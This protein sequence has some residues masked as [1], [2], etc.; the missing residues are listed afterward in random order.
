ML[1]DTQKAPGRLPPGRRVYAIGD[2]HGCGEQL[3]HLHAAIVADLHRR[4]AADP[5]L[6]HLGDYVDR[7]PDIAG[8][9]EKLAVGDPIA[10]L[11]T[12][13]LLGN[14]ERTMLDALMGDRAAATDWLY[15]GGRESLASYGIHPDDDPRDVWTQRVP[16]S[17]V[18]FLKGLTLMHREGS[19][20]FAHA[21]IRPGV[22]LHAQEKHDLI[23]IRTTFLFSEAD[24]GAVVVHGHTPTPTRLP[25]IKANRIA[26]DTGAVYGG[27]LT[28]AVLED[29]TVG[30]LYA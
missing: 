21:G 5:L 25:V 1:N 24:F 27:K 28:C 2:I 6:I 29:D 14:H 9:M 22:A 15:T 17:H 10:G 19:Y 18:D 4:R 26:L 13:N 16:Q 12:V 23:T 3:A 7:G 11:P 20:L 8:V 30:F